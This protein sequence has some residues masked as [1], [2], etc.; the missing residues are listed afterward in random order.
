M[1]GYAWL[2][3]SAYSCAIELCRGEQTDKW[4]YYILNQ[5]DMF[6]FHNV[7]VTMVFDGANLPAKKE[8]EVAR[9]DSRKRNLEKA[10]YL[11]QQNKHTDAYN[12]FSQAVDISPRMAAELIRVLRRNRP[13]VNICV[14]PYEADAQLALLCK[15]GHV[16]VVVGEDSDTIPFACTEMIYKLAKDGSCTYITEL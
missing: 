3:K 12:H 7:H 1:D 14:A 9:A 4:I 2:H 13:E 8:T 15:E 5:I 10:E 6:T 16:D 11:S